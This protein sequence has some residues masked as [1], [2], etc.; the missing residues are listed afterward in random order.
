LEIY[1]SRILRNNVRVFGEKGRSII[2]VLKRDAV[3]LHSIMDVLNVLLDDSHMET[4][5]LADLKT[6]LSGADKSLD[7]T[8]PPA[9]RINTT[10]FASQ[11]I[12]IR[13]E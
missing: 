1:Q 4:H 12:C 9:I 10:L 3:G 8:S 7:R 5:E 2:Q 13:N 11:I 6:P